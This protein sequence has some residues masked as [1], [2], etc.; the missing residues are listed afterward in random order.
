[1][2]GAVRSGVDVVR[3]FAR[4]VRAQLEADGALAG[5]VTE[6]AMDPERPSMDPPYVI[7]YVALPQNEDPRLS[8]A[9]GNRIRGR[10]SIVAA[11][12]DVTQAQLVAARVVGQL[13]GWAP[14]V[15]GWAFEALR[16]GDDAMYADTDYSYSPPVTF[17]SIELTAT[18]RRKAQ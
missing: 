8:G 18:A 17:Y 14:P 4:A 2:S 13:D 3:P 16:V 15:T 9:A 11:G 7:M 1:M 5:V 12:I 6:Q 10:I